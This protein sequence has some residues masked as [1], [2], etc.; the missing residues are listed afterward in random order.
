MEGTASPIPVEGI[1]TTGVQMPGPLKWDVRKVQM[2]K[3]TGKVKWL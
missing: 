1:V 2:T 3:M